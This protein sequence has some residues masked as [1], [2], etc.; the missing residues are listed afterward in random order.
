MLAAHT[1]VISS[2]V[3]R[4][5][6]NACGNS[7]LPMIDVMCGR[8]VVLQDDVHVSICLC[9]QTLLDLLTDIP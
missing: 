5:A 1:N 2:N 8:L 3:Q 4:R 9:F 6:V 7:I